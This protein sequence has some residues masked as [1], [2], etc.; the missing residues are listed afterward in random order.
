[1]V[2]QNIIGRDEEVRKLERFLQSSKSEFVAI[3]GRRRVGKSFLVEEVYRD[4]IVF[5]AIGS[6]IKEKDDKSY[7]QTQLDH[8][9]ESLLDQGVSEDT[10]RPTNWRE[11][12]R[13]LRK[14]LESVNCERRV[15]FLDELP[16]LA[17]PQSSEL[18]MELGYF[19][20]SWADRQRNIV[21][22]V[23]GSA[24]SW[25]LDNV[26]RD[27]GGLHGR[28]TGTIRLLPFRLKECE[29]YFK[30]HGFHLSRY[31][32]A[33]A[34]MAFGGIPYYLDR[35]DNEKNLSENIDDFFFKDARID[36]EFRDVYAGLYATSE[37]YVDIVKTL[38][39]KFYGMTR[40][41]LAEA[42]GIELGG[43]FSKLLDNLQQSGIIREY[44]RYGKERV[45]TVYQL[46][47]FFSM[48]YLHFI[49]RKGAAAGNWRSMQRTPAF[50]AWAGNTFE[51]LCIEHLAQMQDRL[52]I[53]TIN[54]NYCWS[55][56]APNGRASQIDLV[57]EWK[58]ERTDYLCEMKFSE[59]EFTIDKAYEMELAN[60]I[61]A[62]LHCK[63]HTKT[64]S[65]Q[66]VMVTTQ[67]ITQNEHSKDVNQEILLDD[68]FA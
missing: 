24:T 52:R 38:G 62:F 35:I 60:K 56:K 42:I 25:M 55:G 8:F 4:K 19:W 48:F 39:T 53:A 41:E 6:Y 61:D 68:L 20:N 13:L 17:G 51:M 9:Y 26:I 32:M 36:Q 21:L 67:G 15:I 58:G 14:F 1:M 46:K 5:R 31:E 22:V 63:Q 3:Y 30:S 44:P 18:I 33:V 29:M 2:Y 23:C 49:Y 27:Y 34:Y 40:S 37:R 11:A 54:R 64:H 7:K 28:L 66:L 50:Y 43:T 65:V 57:L 45:E 12:F 47:D 16:W 59:H 10:P